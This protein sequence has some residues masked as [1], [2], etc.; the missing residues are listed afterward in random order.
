MKRN[1]LAAL[2]DKEPRG[3]TRRQS[4]EIFRALFVEGDA[5]GA[6]GGAAAADGASAGG[7]AGAGG[8]AQAG[9]GADT[10]KTGGAAQAGDKPAGSAAEN[11]AKLD[12]V[13]DATAKPPEVVN[14]EDQKALLIKNGAKAE[15]V[16]KLKP[17]ELQAK[18]DEAKAAEG[19][20]PAEKGELKITMPEGVEI[21]EAD[22]AN[23]KAILSDDKMKPEERGQALLEMHAKALKAAGEQPLQLWF[24]TQV[25][26]QGE[27]KA[28]KELGGTNFDVTRANMAKAVSEVMGADAAAT[29]EALKFTGAAN[30][31]AIVRLVA[32][33]SKAYVEGTP[34]GGAAPGSVAN[35]DFASRV[36][37]MYPSATGSQ[38]AAQ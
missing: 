33:F 8:V 36:A 20:P 6:A 1:H 26:W 19:K 37:A 30:H 38:P 24:D 4:Y 28:D 7:N 21:P 14:P 32:R 11:L 25:K 12:G 27:V 17:E 35:K 16:D 31:P 13:I 22:L 3:F 34:V 18:Y 5:A 23:F 15:D 2:T 9:A 29:F 10:G